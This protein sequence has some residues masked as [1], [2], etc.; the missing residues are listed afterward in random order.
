MA[1][2]GM[3]QAETAARLR[4][5]VG[6]LARQIRQ[7]S[8]TGLSPTLLSALATIDVDGPITL[9]ELAARERVAPPSISK[10]IEK[11][12][13]LGYVVRTQ[14]PDDRRVHRVAISDTG[15]SQLVEHRELG[16]AWLA[17]RIEAL[18]EHDIDQLDTVLEVLEH[19]AGHRSGES[20]AGAAGAKQATR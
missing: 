17:Q 15:H 18:P 12:E 6:R 2:M 11:L 7:Q 1:R 3:T 13:L 9:G 10:G 14:D 8:H 5:A 16:A 4:L 19:L 20:G